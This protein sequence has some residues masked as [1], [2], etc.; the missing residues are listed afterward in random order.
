[1]GCLPLLLKWYLRST[2]L[3]TTASELPAIKPAA[4]EGSRATPMPGSN[5]PAASGMPM[6]L[7]ICR[8]T[9]ETAIDSDD[10]SSSQ[11]SAN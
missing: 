3:L 7:Y 10:I 6:R 4:T 2:E 9:T 5:A 8:E 1:M 11:I